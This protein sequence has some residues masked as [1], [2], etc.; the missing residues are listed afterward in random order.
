MREAALD[1]LS[2]TVHPPAALRGVLVAMVVC[3][4]E[5]SVMLDA[6]DAVHNWRAGCPPGDALG[7]LLEALL[8]SV[9]LGFADPA[10]PC[11]GR[12]AWG[13]AAAVHAARRLRYIT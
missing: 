3:G 8:E 5:H 2:D 12:V 7:P 11:P 4:V 1:A 10:D 13:G 9:P 6:H